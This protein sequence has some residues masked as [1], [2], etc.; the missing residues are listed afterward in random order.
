MCESEGD[1]SRGAGNKPLQRH[2]RSFRY[3]GNQTQADNTHFLFSTGFTRALSR[4]A[5]LLSEQLHRDVS[6]SQ[7]SNAGLLS[8][9]PVHV[10]VLL[11]P[12]PTSERPSAPA[13]K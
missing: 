1:S 10:S 5:D 2:R 12:L 6:G 3:F 8:F 4:V 9:L 7:S 11:T 13:R